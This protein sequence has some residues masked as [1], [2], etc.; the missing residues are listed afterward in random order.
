MFHHGFR[1][2]TRSRASGRLGFMMKRFLTMGLLLSVGT[3]EARA[4]SGRFEVPPASLPDI[5]NGLRLGGFSGLLIDAVNGSKVSLV[6]ITDRGPNRDQEACPENNDAI[7]RPFL[8]PMFTPELVFADLDLSTRQLTVRARKPLR[9]SSSVALSGRPWSNPASGDQVYEIPVDVERRVLASDDQGIDP[10]GLVRS[11]NGGF[12]IIEEYGPSLLEV[13]AE[14]HTLHRWGPSTWPEPVRRRE[15]NRGFESI[16]M[17]GGQLWMFLES[18]PADG[19][20]RSLAVVFDPRAERV[21]ALYAYAFGEG[22]KKLGDAATDA[23][24]NLFV[25]EQNSKS[26]RE[27]IHRIVQIDPRNAT[28]L[29]GTAA[30][31]WKRAIKD[32]TPLG[33]TERSDFAGFGYDREKVEGLALF[34]GHRYLI[35]NDNDFGVNEGTS[36]IIEFGWSGF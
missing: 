9:S 26:G 25:I 14:G 12:F 2:K 11:P 10:E 34:E 32:A 24:G 23:Q 29:M 27:G 19:G 15:M 13:D 28:N 21:T 7:C 6:T 30:N 33:R 35:L 8:R 4:V 17:V 5:G 3:V 16:A 36:S 1:K 20:K 22:A 18:A 31:R